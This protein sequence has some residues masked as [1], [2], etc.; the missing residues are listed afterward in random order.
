M[1]SLRRIKH[2]K[3]LSKYLRE[4][5]FALGIKSHVQRIAASSWNPVHLEPVLL[6]EISPYRI[7][8]LVGEP[9]VTFSVELHAP[10]HRSKIALCLPIW[11]FDV[12]G[13]RLGLRIKNQQVARPCRCYPYIVICVD[14]YAYWL[15]ARKWYGK[16]GDELILLG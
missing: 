13:N 2:C 11:D 7:V 9:Q 8:Y 16:L 15:R 6:H 5:D 4:P 12:S 10:N 1:S 3:I 14:R